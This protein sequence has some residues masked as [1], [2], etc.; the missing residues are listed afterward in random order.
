MESKTSEDKALSPSGTKGIAE[1]ISDL[2]AESIASPKEKK[3]V[4]AEGEKEP[5]ET[6]DEKKEAAKQGPKTRLFILDKETGQ[7]IPAVFKSEGKER[8]PDSADKLLTWA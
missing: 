4:I 1:G 8:I 6:C 2:V 7:E 5:C 3:E